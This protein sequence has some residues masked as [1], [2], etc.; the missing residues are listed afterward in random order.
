MTT[1]HEEQPQTEALAT[2]KVT[3]APPRAR[4]RFANVPSRLGR[5]RTS[6]VVLAVLFVAVFVLWVYV[7]PPA[8]ASPAGTTGDVNGPVAPATSSSVPTTTSEAPTPTP[9]GS[10]TPPRETT[11]EPSTPTDQTTGGAT[12]TA[13]ESSTPGRSSTGVSVPSATVPA[14]T[15]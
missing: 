8:V 2:P 9:S 10:T 7:R 5:A 12:T 15:S 4:W 3:T 11:T 14:P 6:T 1:P 13:P